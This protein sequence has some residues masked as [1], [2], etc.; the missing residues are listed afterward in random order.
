MIIYMY[1]SK[2]N[3]CLVSSDHS[4][5]SIIFSCTV[6]P[7]FNGHCYERSSCNWETLSESQ[8]FSM[9]EPVM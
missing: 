3:P 7:V 9:L 8:N 4:F 2:G 1:E 5:Y 6:K